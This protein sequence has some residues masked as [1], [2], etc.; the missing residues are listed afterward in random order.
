MK[1]KLTERRIARYLWVAFALLVA[2]GCL[3]VL[4]LDMGWL[5]YMP[6]MKRMQNPISQYASRVYSADG[7]LMGTW[8]EA[9]NRIF[10]G[11]DSI[12]P[13]VYDALISTE[14]ERFYEHSGVDARSVGRA[15]VKRGLMRQQSAGGGSTITQQLAKQLYSERSHS[16]VQ[17]LFQKPVEWVIAVELERTFTKEEILTFYLNY[18]DFLHNAVGIRTA[19]R[20]YFDKHPRNLSVNEAATLIGMCKNPS[21]YNPVRYPQ[22]AFERRNVVLGQ[23][24]KQ[25]KLTQAA[26]DSLSHQPI[27]LRF[28]TIDYKDGNNVYMMEYLRR[29]M[30]AHQPD[31]ENYR[32]WQEQQFVEDSTAWADDPLYGWCNKN[33]K[34][35][36][37]PYNIYSDGLRV[38]TTIDSRM[39]QYAEEAVRQH[40]GRTLQPAFYNS[41]KSQPNFPYT[42]RLSSKTIENIIRRNMRSSHR[43]QVLREE[44]WDEDRIVKNFD[45]PVRMT[46]FTYNGDI[47][48]TMTPRDSIMYYKKY[49]RSSLFSIEPQTGYVKAYVGGLDYAHFQYDMAMTGRRQIGSTMKPFVYT[50]AL[51]DGRLPDDR[52]QNIRRVYRVGPERWSPRNGSRAAYGSH[53]TLE[54]GLS[55]SNNWVTAEV[56]NMTDPTGHRLRTFLHNFGINTTKV[57]PSIALCLGPSEISASELAS[58]YTAFVNKG[59]R[60]PPVFVTRIEDADGNVIAEFGSRPN[61]VISEATS[62]RMIHMLEGVVNHGTA[63]RLRGS[64]FTGD[65]AGKTGTT[66]NNSD[67]W[68]VGLVPRLVT[69]VWVGG[70]DRDIHF[71]S[72]AMGQGAAAALPVWAI[73]M[74][75]VYADDDLGYSQK[76]KFDI[77]DE[78]PEG[79]EPM[80]TASGK[81]KDK[82]KDRRDARPAQR[83]KPAEA[84]KEEGSLSSDDKGG[85]S[86]GNGGGESHPAAP[87]QPAA[88]APSKPA[89]SGSADRLFE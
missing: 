87:A 47:D 61:E 65:V 11:Y 31:R 70:E 68:F 57:V 28:H 79:P 83:R 26:Y 35:D 55:H 37:T 21:L 60:C 41:K 80:L 20:V 45:V 27:H 39:Q 76:E 12:A 77:P 4:A 86:G 17:R 42:S 24:V 71:D 50:L 38:Y 74:K 22:R 81:D 2:L 34:A 23:M 7:K 13:A 43:Y 46:I 1:K 88:P 18:F 72:G 15:V 5:G 25:G 73:Y 82:D 66:N 58:A 67:A 89:S 30:M 62:Y 10:V 48:T 8:S 56:M 9:G 6:D 54:W 3:V 59:L 63:H 32:K 40:V 36:G 53:V 44:G 51:E 16:A 33:T 78:M 69:A 84:K 19:A 64:G 75:K 29:V 14:D 52:V 49:L 85:A